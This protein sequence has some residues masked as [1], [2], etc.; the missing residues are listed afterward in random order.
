MAD[1]AEIEHYVETASPWME[2]V[3]LEATDGE[4][5]KSRKFK[6]VQAAIV[7]WNEDNSGANEDKDVSVVNSDGTEI[8][9]SDGTVLLNL[10]DGVDETVTLWLF[11]RG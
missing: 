3:R 5:Y 1:A 8:D 7:C 2:V 6:Y 11:G 9:G 4:I 10:E